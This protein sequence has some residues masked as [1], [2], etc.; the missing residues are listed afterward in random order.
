MNTAAALQH[1]ICLT[2]CT[3]EPLMNYLKALGVVRLVGEQK[4]AAARGWWRNE[5]FWLRSALDRSSL[6]QFFLDEYA[7]TPIISPW[8]KDSFFLKRGK[9][10]CLAELLN[11]Q[12]PRF[13]TYRR[14]IEQLQALLN[15]RR[16]R[17]MPEKALE[18]Y[19]K[20]NKQLLL[21]TLRREL[22]DAAVAWLDTAV[23]LLENDQHFSP[24]LGSG[25]NDGR[26][27]FVN[28]FMTCLVKTLLPAKK[29]SGNSRE[30]LEQSL[31]GRPARLDGA[32]KI[33][34][35]APGNVGG[36]NATQGFKDESIVNPWD[37]VLMLEG[38][39]LMT[40]AVSR[41]YELAAGTQAAFPFIVDNVEAGFSSPG[42]K[43]ADKPRGELWL[44]L[45]ERPAGADELR[46]LYGEGR[47]EVSRRRAKIGTDVAR[48]AVELGVDRGIRSF[49]RLGFLRRSGRSFLAVPLGRFDVQARPDAVLFR[50]VDVWCDRFRRA[51]AGKSAPPRF[52]A[53]LR[54][55]D[56][57]VFDFCRYG[58]AARLQR[59]LI[60]LGRAERELAHTAGKIGSSSALPPLGRL[61]PDWIAAA[62]D[63]TA[64]FAVALSLAM[65]EGDSPT[66]KHVGPF[67]CNLE[68]VAPKGGAWTWAENSRAAVWNVADLAANLIHVLQRRAMDSAAAGSSQLPIS[69]PYAV[70]LGDVSAFLR[71][72]LDDARIEDLIWGLSL[73]S[74]CET[75]VKTKRVDAGDW[76]GLPRNYALLKLLFL[77]RP[78]LADIRDGKPYWR[79]AR[80][81]EPGLAIRPEPRILPLLRAGRSGEAC[82]IAVQRLRAAGLVPLAGDTRSENAW[83]EF[84]GDSRRLAAALLLPLSS[85]AI[86]RMV[87]LVCR[88][89]DLETAASS[90][91]TT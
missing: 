19:L 52:A 15:A 57:A 70:P 20:K 18:E 65:I 91:I 42:T 28:N 56:A 35:F 64:E 87:N 73:V 78:L 21:R 88:A 3:P 14:T 4:D 84:A 22:P 23:A 43:S 31:F 80:Q 60:A 59:V 29:S 8:N 10:N 86:N 72:Q 13:E 53:A 61:S 48:A 44:P 39:L 5:A 40:A 41:R 54:A 37:Y 58:G 74:P 46:L 69:S 33:G 36:P 17:T 7:P 9:E 1:D 76:H 62:D 49:H 75:R 79:L 25:C 77:P 68:P 34:Q 63:G 90:I 82:R 16:L 51:A 26:M 6:L 27:E 50:Q 32:A 66:Q 89:D 45:W 12:D 71:A 2:G 67:R 11:S 81:D 47:A 30:W 85:K 38:A 24:L 55:I 83:T